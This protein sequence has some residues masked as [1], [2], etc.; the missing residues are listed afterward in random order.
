MALTLALLE[1][2]LLFVAVF[3]TSVL[4]WK[5]GRVLAAEQ[6]P[7]GRSELARPGGF[8]ELGWPPFGGPLP[9]L[10]GS[11]IPHPEGGRSRECS[12]IWACCRKEVN[13]SPLPP[14]KP[15]APK[16]PKPASRR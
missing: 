5:P 3:A 4:L 2:G 13:S 11:Q 7:S 8:R 1:G 12:T 15:D 14:A 9:T 10:F 6:T 16:G